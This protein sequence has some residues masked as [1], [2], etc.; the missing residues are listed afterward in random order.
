MSTQHVFGIPERANTLSLNV[1]HYDKPYRLFNQDYYPHL[2]GDN[3]SLYGSVPYIMGHSEEVDSSVAWM[4]SAETFV[5]IN[6]AHMGERLNSAFISEGNALEFYLLAAEGSP[7]KL[8]KKLSELTGYLEIPPIHSLGFH[9]SKYENMTA[10]DVVKRSHTF[11]HYEFPVDVLWFDIEHAWK[12]QYTE[13]HYE[14]F[15]MKDVMRMNDVIADAKRRFVV[16][17]D[18]HIRANEEFHI[19]NEGLKKQHGV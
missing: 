2:L 8:Q 13:F 18:P 7:K 10:H 11:D 1:T 16:I 4:N 6:E 9:Y 17:V 5:F 15:N 14:N 19:Y 12:H 3:T